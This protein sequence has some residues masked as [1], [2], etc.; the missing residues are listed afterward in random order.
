MIRKQLMP[1]LE[2][3]GRYVPVVVVFIFVSMLIVLADTHRL[4]P[5]LKIVERAPMGDK[6][7]HL[8][9]FGLLAATLNS[10]L[11]YRKVQ[12]AY[13][14]LQWGSLVVLVFGVTEELSQL[15]FSART[16]DLRDMLANVIGIGLAN[17]WG[18][19]RARWKAD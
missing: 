10:A 1:W 11:Q 12:I 2:S 14:L 19:I 18:N 15:G 13:G 8:S 5:I 16:F 4:E 17:W 9:L 3:R 6:V 7:A